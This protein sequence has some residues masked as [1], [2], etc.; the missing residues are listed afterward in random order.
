[1]APKQYTL[2]SSVLSEKDHNLDWVYGTV[3]FLKEIN[4]GTSR[5]GA[6]M[7]L[8]DGDGGGHHHSTRTTRHLL[9]LVQ[10]VCGEHP[11]DK[12]LDYK[13]EWAFPGS[14]KTQVR[15][16][17]GNHFKRSG[18]AKEGSQESIEISSKNPSLQATKL[19]A[20]RERTDSAWDLSSQLPLRNTLGPLKPLPF[21]ACR[22]G[23]PGILGVS[24]FNN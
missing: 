13:N 22:C 14:C 16:R 11:L 24:T 4:L 5:T 9:R 23:C 2:N 18:N 19:P 3:R 20:G 7:I 10:E 1:M 6:K 17:W 15:Q 8:G 12:D 21:N